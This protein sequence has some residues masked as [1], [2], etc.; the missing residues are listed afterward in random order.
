MARGRWLTPRGGLVARRRP[1]EA[2]YD[3]RVLFS[4]S[5]MTLSD[6]WKAM[7][8]SFDSAATTNFRTHSKL[9]PL[10]PTYLR[11]T[12]HCMLSS[13][14]R[15]DVGC[16]HYE[17]PQLCH[18]T[19]QGHPWEVCREEHGGACSKADERLAAP[20]ENDSQYIWYLMSVRAHGVYYAEYS[21]V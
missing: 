13:P 9:S 15:T 1:T 16:A 6:R 5:R 7:S 14:T 12:H 10:K 19:A 18:S 3:R 21:V 11:H 4:S 20:M 8:S 2:A 17:P